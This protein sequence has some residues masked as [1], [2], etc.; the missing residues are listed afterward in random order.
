[1]ITAVTRGHAL[2]E[3]GHRAAAVELAQL[4]LDQLFPSWERATTGQRIIRAISLIWVVTLL[5]GLV[6][7]VAFDRLGD[8]NWFTFFFLVPLAITPFVQRRRL[9]RTI[10]LNSEPSV[11]D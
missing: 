10:A 4:T 2:E 3:P 11:R 9:L 5:A 1:M 7:A 6:F 8:V